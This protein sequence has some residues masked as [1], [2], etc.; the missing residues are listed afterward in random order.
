MTNSQNM[1]YRGKFWLGSAMQEIEVM[2][3]LGSA[4]PWVLSE[5][6]GVEDKPCPYRK[7]RYMETDSK[8]FVINTDA[9]K[10]IKYGVGEIVGSPS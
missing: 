7:E 10:T 5:T 3:D 9:T 1:V 2:F 8:S 6:C 4:Y